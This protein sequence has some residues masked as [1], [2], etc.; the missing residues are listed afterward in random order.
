M[1][2]FCHA[3]WAKTSFTNKITIAITYIVSFRWFEG[4][5]DHCDVK[6]KLNTDVFQIPR[7]ISD[8]CTLE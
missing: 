7:V 8:I 4:L 5:K 6:K 1:S 2:V 3:Y